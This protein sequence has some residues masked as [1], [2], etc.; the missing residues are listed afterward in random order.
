MMTPDLLV[1]T[2][3][4]GAAFL[5]TLAFL[6]YSEHQQW[7][8]YDRMVDRLHA[9]GYQDMKAAD[10]Y[11]AGVKRNMDVAAQVLR[12]EAEHPPDDPS[13]LGN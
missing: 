10:A 5:S 7:K 1:I 11:A 8:R 13:S 4:F 12:D 6:I 9:G 2:C 3:S